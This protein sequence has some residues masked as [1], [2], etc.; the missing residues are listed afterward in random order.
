MPGF[1]EE[2]RLPALKVSGASSTSGNHVPDIIRHPTSSNQDALSLGQHG[3]ASAASRSSLTRLLRPSQGESSEINLS[4]K[5]DTDDL[6]SCSSVPE[7]PLSAIIK[8]RLHSFAIK[9]LTSSLLKK[10][11]HKH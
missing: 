11:K 9:A 7:A 6:T 10:H 1:Q 4:P 3:H 2:T 5:D 8:V